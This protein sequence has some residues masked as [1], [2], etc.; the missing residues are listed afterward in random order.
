[1]GIYSRS[2]SKAVALANPKR[3]TTLTYEVNSDGDTESISATKLGKGTF[4][5]AYLGDDGMV[6][7][8]TVEDSRI[9]GSEMTKSMLAD[10]NRREGAQAFIPVLEH[11]GSKDVRKEGRIA[12]A[13]VYR[14]PLYKAPLRK[15]DSPVAWALARQLKK[16]IGHANNSIPYRLRG[17]YDSRHQRQ[18]VVDYLTDAPVP[19]GVSDATYEDFVETIE[20]LSNEAANYGELSFEAPPRNLATDGNKQ[21]ILLDVL[22]DRKSLLQSRGV[23]C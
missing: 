2:M 19:K 11:V 14:S 12:Y 1:M 6:Y 18:Y 22:F 16:A 9:K 23:R 4:T 3:K 21:L 20:Y 10:L 13:E 5:T 8:V 7:L 15:A 17:C